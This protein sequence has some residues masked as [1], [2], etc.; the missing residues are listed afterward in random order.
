MK[1]AALMTV[2][3]ISMSTALLAQNTDRTS[4]SK[5]EKG[6]ATHKATGVVKSVD[7]KRATATLAHGPVPA[8]KWRSMTM[9]F[10]VKDKA[11]FD[12]LQP[13]KKVEFEFVQQGKDHVITSVN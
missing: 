7:S 8:L 4:R 3:A 11:T 13:G 12:K 6:Q 1:A 2:L 9:S 5:G 10:T